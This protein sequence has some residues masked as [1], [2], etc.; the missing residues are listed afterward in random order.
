MK[1]FKLGMSYFLQAL[2]YTVGKLQHR[3]STWVPK[4]TEMNSAL[5]PEPKQRQIMR[6]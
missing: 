1:E 6:L 2:E 5:K 3:S 4:S